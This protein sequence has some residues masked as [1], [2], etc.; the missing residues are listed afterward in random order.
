MSWLAALVSA[1]LA[2][3]T[4]WAPG[5]LVLRAWGWRA[6]PVLRCAVALPVTVALLGVPP[7]VLQGRLRWGVPVAVG[8]VVAACAGGLLVR[9]LR[10]ESEP[11]AAAT[12]APRA[13][14]LGIAGAT[15]LQLLPVAAGMRRPDALLTA[16]DTT[17]HQAAVAWVR[18]TGRGSSLSLQESV[19]RPTGGVTFYG[20]G[21][22]DV[23]ALVPTWPDPAV[24]STVTM[25][26]PVALAWTLGITALTRATLPSRPRAWAWAPWL[27]VGGVAL[28]GYLVL[29]PE[30]MTANALGL[31][32]VPALLA[33]V[34]HAGRRAGPSWVVVAVAAAGLAL[35][36]PNALASTVVVLAPV[37]LLRWLPAVARRRRPWHLVAGVV[38]VG[39]VACGTALVVGRRI[40]ELLA[41]YPAEAPLGVPEAVLQL[42]SG[43]A[44]GMGWASGFLVVALGALGAWWGRRLPGATVW[45]GAAALV[46]LYLL[47]TSSAPWTSAAGTLWWGEPRRFAPLVGAVLVPPAALALD[48]LAGQL[49]Q[50]MR[51]RPSRA[52][53]ATVLGLLVLAGA[54]P[55]ALGHAE[56]ARA[57]FHPTAGD[58]ALADDA[59]LDM[60]R[61]V[62]SRLDP[63]RAVLGSPFAGAVAL[64]DRTGQRLVSPAS[65]AQADPRAEAASARLTTVGVDPETCRLLHELEVGYLYVDPAPWNAGPGLADLRSAPPSGVRLLDQGGSAAVY[66]V[67]AC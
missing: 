28:P 13:V 1:V 58:A 47:M 66:E 55:A 7:M 59:E 27:S 43:N 60:L 6:D 62:A 18:A 5:L 21:W 31:A 65:N 46:L 22:H 36:H 44:T 9:R 41:A 35:C 37:A 20:A 57:T 24:V 50:R 30:G 33:L 15:L 26:V 52:S 39:A 34:H 8:V 12:R 17:F 51:P 25:L 63:D 61:R 16:H 19:G 29:R 56:L 54:V 3:A 11:D 14:V 49:R 53:A 38:T 2:L 40:L 10:H 4:F 64:L 32:A 23:A 45:W 67:T 42:L 48:T